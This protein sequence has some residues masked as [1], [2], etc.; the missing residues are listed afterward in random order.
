[1]DIDTKYTRD[2]KVANFRGKAQ[3]VAAER[4]N[5]EFMKDDEQKNILCTSVGCAFC[6]L[7]A[8]FVSQRCMFRLSTNTV[9][10]FCIHCIFIYYFLFAFPSVFCWLGNEKV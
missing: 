3:K 2:E 4:T 6:I 5:R 9:C 7:M 8:S 1:M 10:V